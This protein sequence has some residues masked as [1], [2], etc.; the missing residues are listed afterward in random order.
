ME[1]PIC[2]NKV[3][4]C[5]IKIIEDLKYFKIWKQMVDK[6]LINQ[7]NVIVNVSML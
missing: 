7:S 5:L 6:T 1:K 3:N 4:A 2:F